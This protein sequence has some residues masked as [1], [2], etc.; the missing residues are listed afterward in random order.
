MLFSRNTN[1]VEHF[2]S[3]WLVLTWHFLLEW[4]SD[5][6]GKF[7]WLSTGRSKCHFQSLYT[8]PKDPQRKRR[9]GLEPEICV[10]LQKENNNP[11]IYQFLGA[12]WQCFFPGVYTWICLRCFFLDCT[13]VNFHEEYVNTF[14]K[15]HGL[16]Q[17][18]VIISCS[19]NEN[20]MIWWPF[21]KGPIH[22][23]LLVFASKLSCG[24][25]EIYSI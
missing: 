7:K 18:Q 15:H 24:G 10:S 12:S 19:K 4:W 16:P 13:T 11:T 22:G 9:A 14:S 20:D 1:L 25:Q 21:W 8:N 6:C 5:A 17:I 23:F 2:E 3:S